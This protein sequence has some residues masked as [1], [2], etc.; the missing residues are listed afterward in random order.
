ML[1]LIL[2]KYMRKYCDVIEEVS[3]YCYNMVND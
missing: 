3:I 1:M 2:I